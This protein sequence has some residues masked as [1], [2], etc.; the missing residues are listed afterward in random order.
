M[1]ALPLSLGEVHADHR[2]LLRV[3][4]PT[5]ARCVRSTST[6]VIPRRPRSY[7][8]CRCLLGLVRDHVGKRRAASSTTAMATHVGEGTDWGTCFNEVSRA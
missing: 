8:G 6:R 5:K 4:T 2:D 7:L 1:R 3:R